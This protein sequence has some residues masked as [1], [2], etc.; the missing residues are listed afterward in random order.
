MLK[1]V[2][3]AIPMALLLSSCDPAP[4][5]EGSYREEKKIKKVLSSLDANDPK[6]ELPDGYYRRKT[7]D[8]SPYIITGTD[9]HKGGG[10]VGILFA[11]GTIVTHFCHVCGPGPTPLESIKG[12]TK[13][14]V[15]ASLKKRPAH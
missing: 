12:D 15:I 11:D 6:Q 7:G 4:E 2:Y 10:T 3:I 1:K 13:D 14:E 8:G 5:G 9:S